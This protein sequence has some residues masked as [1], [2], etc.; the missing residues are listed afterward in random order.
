[1]MDNFEI[2]SVHNTHII[3]DLAKFIEVTFNIII[4]EDGEFEMKKSDRKWTGIMV[5]LVRR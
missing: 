3:Q 5:I 1:M 2:L 4:P